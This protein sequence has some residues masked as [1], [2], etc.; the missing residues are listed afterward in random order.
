[1]RAL[2]VRPSAAVT[3]VPAADTILNST[4]VPGETSI[5]RMIIRILYE[6]M[7]TAVLNLD[8]IKFSTRNGKRRN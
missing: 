6:S 2:C 5:I 3:A 4:Q 1:M 7:Y 8:P